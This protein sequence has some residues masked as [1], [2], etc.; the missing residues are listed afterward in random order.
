MNLFQLYRYDT[1]ELLFEAKAVCM[2]ECLEKAVWDKVNLDYVDLSNC[3][4][5]DINLDDAQI[6]YANFRGCTLVGANMSEGSFKGCDFSNALLHGACLNESDFGQAAF[7]YTRFGD[8]DCAGTNFEGTVFAGVSALE[9]KFQECLSMTNCLYYHHDGKAYP[10]SRPPLVIK[11]LPYLLALL[12]KHYIKGSE[13]KSSDTLLD[14]LYGPHNFGDLNLLEQIDQRP[15]AD[16][17]FYNR[18][19]IALAYDRYRLQKKSC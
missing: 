7:I 11:G 13:I 12:N 19:I 17:V 14:D 2:K 8:T 5:C 1:N 4:L 18:M 16:R 6:H 3:N 9:L 10:M 15:F